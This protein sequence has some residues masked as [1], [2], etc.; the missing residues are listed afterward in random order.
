MN[1]TWDTLVGGKRSHHCAIPAPSCWYAHT[2]QTDS[3]LIFVTFVWDVSCNFQ[4]LVHGTVTTVFV[5]TWLWKTKHPQKRFQNCH[6]SCVL[7]TDQIKIHQS[8]P[9]SMT[10][11]RLEGHTSG[12]NWWLSIRT[13]NNMQDW[14]KLWKCFCGRFFF[15]KSHVNENSGNSW[16]AILKLNRVKNSSGLKN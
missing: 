2:S 11:R 9:D 4:K 3:R 10:W 15:P 6:Q 13:V 8:R 16:L 12:C 5:H 14:W 1:R 7:L